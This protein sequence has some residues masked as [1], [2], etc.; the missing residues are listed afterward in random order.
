MT[1]G[2]A[3]ASQ[4]VGPFFSIA[5]SRP[6][7]QNLASAGPEGERIDIEGRVLDGAGAPVPDAVLEIWQA[8]ARGRYAHPDDPRSADCDPGFIGFGRASTGADGSYAFATIRPGRC[9][10]ADGRLQAPHVALSV[11]ARGLLRRHDHPQPQ[12]RGTSAVVH[13]LA[14]IKVM[15]R[16]DRTTAR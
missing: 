10:G 5:L 4:T 14:E 1:A 2:P 11:F 16:F 15:H 3:T 6:A 9:A 8:D 12:A 13:A 7:W